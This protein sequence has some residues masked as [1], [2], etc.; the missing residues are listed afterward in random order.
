M[1]NWDVYV[2]L[3]V[4]ATLLLFSLISGKTF[5]PLRGMRPMIVTR[6][7]R[8]YHLYINFIFFSLLLTLYHVAVL[9]KKLLTLYHVAILIKKNCEIVYVFLLKNS[10]LGYLINVNFSSFHA[11]ASGRQLIRLAIGLAS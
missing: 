9:I 4:I 5:N 2:P 7:E 3:L 8:P 1:R 11:L 6:E 10:V